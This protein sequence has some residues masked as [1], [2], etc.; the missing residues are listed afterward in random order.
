MQVL[1]GDDLKQQAVSKSHTVPLWHSVLTV[2]VTCDHYAPRV[3]HVIIMHIM[4]AQLEG[5]DR[6]DSVRGRSEAA[7]RVEKDRPAQSQTLIPIP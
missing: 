4:H 3:S 7:S 2:F 6:A 5:R 1:F